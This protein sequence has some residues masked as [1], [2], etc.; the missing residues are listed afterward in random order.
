M[1]HDQVTSTH[2]GVPVDA[3]S[4]QARGRRLVR[5]SGSIAL[6]SGVVACCAEFVA[7]NA[8]AD[9]QG[10]AELEAQLRDAQARVKELEQTLTKLSSELDALKEQKSSHN[11]DAS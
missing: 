6:M 4:R 2:V 11:E 8:L 3:A 5:H 10:V 7:S 9:E 1:A